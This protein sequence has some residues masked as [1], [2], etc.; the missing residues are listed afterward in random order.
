M[1]GLDYTKNKE[2]GNTR[3]LG[4]ERKPFK[5]LRS[6]LYTLVFLSRTRAEKWLLYF[7]LCFGGA[8]FGLSLY[9]I[10]TINTPAP[11]VFACDMEKV[12]EVLEEP[13]L[14]KK[15]ATSTPKKAKKK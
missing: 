9:L 10:Q 13:V 12:R 14:L 11:I 15:T 3:G 6:A 2:L 1:S 8:G 7:S 5:G 4:A